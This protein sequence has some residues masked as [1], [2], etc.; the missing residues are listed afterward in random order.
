M[1]R[2]V[3][4]GLTF[5]GVVWSNAAAQTQ[6]SVQ[7]G[8]RVRVRSTVAHTPELVGVVET[9]KPDTLMV[10]DDDRSMATAVP[11]ATVDRLQV[12]RGRHSKWITGAAVGFVVGAGTGAILGAAGHNESDF[13]F[14]PGASAFLGAVLLAPVGALTGTVVGLLVKTERWQTVPLGRVGPSVGRGPDGRL[15]LGV[16]VAL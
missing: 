4:L 1:Q 13:I 11:L 15:T 12:S 10:R 6:A 5:A 2:A 7:P 14:G 3:L 9:I 8:Q 16:R